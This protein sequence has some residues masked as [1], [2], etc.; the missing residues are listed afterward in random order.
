MGNL[1]QLMLYCCTHFSLH[2][3]LHAGRFG[4]IK[5]SCIMITVAGQLDYMSCIHGIGMIRKI[6]NIYFHAIENGKE[7]IHKYAESNGI[8]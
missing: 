7:N 3:L 1:P 2:S 5:V 6:T 8:I 4:L